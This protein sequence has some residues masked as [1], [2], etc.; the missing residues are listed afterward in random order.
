MYI[1]TVSNVVILHNVILFKKKV[2]SVK[3][4]HYIFLTSTAHASCTNLVMCY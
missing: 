2:T 1:H 3:T 4:F